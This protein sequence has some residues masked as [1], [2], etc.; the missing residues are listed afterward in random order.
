MSTD[1]EHSLDAHPGCT[2]GS[3]PDL[4]PKR[5]RKAMEMEVARQEGYFIVDSPSGSRYTVTLSPVYSCE[6]R[7]AIYREEVC[8]HLCAC[9]LINRDNEAMQIAKRFV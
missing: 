8:K 3:R 2:K 5:V 6:C 9:L 1:D 4:D 7:D